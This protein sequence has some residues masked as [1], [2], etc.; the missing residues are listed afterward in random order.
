MFFK[1]TL[2]GTVAGLSYEDLLLKKGQCYSVLFL[3]NY[4]YSAENDCA[5]TPNN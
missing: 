5:K 3:F 4:K 1:C 2:C